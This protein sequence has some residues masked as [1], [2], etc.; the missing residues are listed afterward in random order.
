[1][2]RFGLLLLLCGVC[3]GQTD[4]KARPT[5][6]SNG[7]LIELAGL[8]PLRDCQVMAVK[9]KVK[10]VKRVDDA[11]IFVLSNK[12][13]RMTFQFP[14][15]RVAPSDQP[16]LSKNFLRKNVML[17]ASGYQCKGPNIALETISITRVYQ[18]GYGPQ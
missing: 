17:N 14:I 2:Q 12:Q 6:A 18:N 8:A 9:G 7:V 10:K 4:P 5:Y 15:N 11:M 13:D 1:M 16:Y 3:F